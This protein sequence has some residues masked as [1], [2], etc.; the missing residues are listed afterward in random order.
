MI[1]LEYLKNVPNELATGKVAINEIRDKVGLSPIPEG[2]V[3]LVPTE[4]Q[5]D[6]NQ[7]QYEIDH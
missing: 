1:D 3:K 7:L 4:T 5:F 2:D 6:S